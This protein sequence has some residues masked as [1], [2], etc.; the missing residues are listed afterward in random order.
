MT[1]TLST[2]IIC[3]VCVIA[4]FFGVVSCLPGGLEY[5]N[6]NEYNAPI[7]LIQGSSLF[8]DSIVATYKVKLDED[9]NINDVVKN[10]RSRLSDMY[11]YYFSNVKVNGDDITVQVPKTANGEN[12]SAAT[13]LSNVTA[14][15]KVEILTESTYSADKVILTAEHVKSMTLRNYSSGANAYYIVNM[16]LTQEGKEIAAEN[17]TPTSYGYSAYI[18]VDGT[19]SYAIVYES[20]QVM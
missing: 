12:T 14:V 2:V 17:I 16:N 8:N 7:N 20:H 3:I 1:K 6:Y 18:A 15:G 9:A 11:G 19:V 10:I 13:I 4:L 5:G